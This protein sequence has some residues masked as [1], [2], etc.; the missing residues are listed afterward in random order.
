MLV[1]EGG[2]VSGG[3]IGLGEVVDASRQINNADRTLRVN[4]VVIVGFAF[5][6]HQHF[7]AVRSKG[8]HVGQSTR[9][10]GIQEVAVDVKEHH[11]AGL[12]FDFVFNG[13]RH[14]AVGDRHAVSSSPVGGGVNVKQL[15]GVAGVANI[16][17][18][19]GR[20][21][22]IDHKQPLGFRIVDHDFSSA[23]VKDPSFVGAEGNQQRRSGIHRGRLSRAIRVSHG[24]V[25]E[26]EVLNAAVQLAS[27]VF[28][29]ELEVK[30]H[31]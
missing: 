28:L 2:K 15:S 10:N 18:F 12:S 30:R 8:H 3:D 6:G 16:Q 13:D 1:I 5:V 19:H 9:S 17:H 7:S 20:N 21:L 4:G 27:G 26:S 11:A 23:F 25:A 22:G 24:V 14:K 31:K 29:V